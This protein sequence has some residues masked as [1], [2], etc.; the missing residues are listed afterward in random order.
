MEFHRISMEEVI[1]NLPD[2]EKLNINS[3]FSNSK[4]DLYIQAIGFEER[5]KSISEKLKTVINF[6]AKEAVLIKY[7]NNVE[8]NLYY[9]EEIKNNVRIFCKKISFI[10]LDDD[11]SEQLRQKLLSVHKNNIPIKIILDFSSL[12]SRLIL[13][14]TKILIN[15]KCELTI[16]YTEGEVYHPTEEEYNILKIKNDNSSVLYQTIGIHN[17]IPSPEY[18]GGIKEHPDL[19][20]CFPSFKAERTEAIISFIDDLILKQR[21]ENRMI[22]VI[23]DPHMQ[24][25]TKSNRRNIQRELNGITEKEKIYHVDTLDYKMT[26]LT[27]DHIYKDVYKFYHI[28]ISDLGSKMQSFGIAL[29]ANLRKDISVYYSEPIKHNP[30]HYADG[31]KDFWIIKIGKVEEFINKLYK[32]DLITEIHY[33]KT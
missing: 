8:D 13:A 18:N 30:S 26:L 25:P 3:E 28:N 16:T 27:L 1:G 6:E 2:V 20:I 12:S 15:R 24:E 14:L 9:E 4:F 5:T 19:V 7:L 33:G 10:K 17:V 31:I 32:V 22:W 21:D 11:F 23:G 29:F